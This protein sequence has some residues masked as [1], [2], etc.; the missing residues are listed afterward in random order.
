MKISAIGKANCINT[1]AISDQ[2]VYQI[3]KESEASNNIDGTLQAIVLQ[4]T[5]R[6]VA[7]SQVTRATNRGAVYIMMSVNGYRRARHSNP[8]AKNKYWNENMIYGALV[9]H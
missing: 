6:T 3:E 1:A 8:K 4:D 9:R 2:I 5:F 7:V